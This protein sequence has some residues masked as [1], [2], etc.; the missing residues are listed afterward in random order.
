MLDDREKRALCEAATSKTRDAL[1]RQKNLNDL[2]AIT[3][4]EVQFIALA[5]LVLLKTEIHPH[6]QIGA[7]MRDQ[8]LA[9]DLSGVIDTLARDCNETFSRDMTALIA[10]YAHL[11]SQLGVSSIQQYRD[12][13]STSASSKETCLQ[14]YLSKCSEIL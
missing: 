4:S 5:R 8:S 6:K 3:K 9:D 11:L 12:T 14:R 10:Y 1:T 13:P 2:A 7:I